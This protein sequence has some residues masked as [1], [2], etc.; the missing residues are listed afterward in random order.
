M[1]SHATG[2]TQ[3]SEDG[4]EDADE[5]LENELPEVLLGIIHR[6]DCGL[7]FGIVDRLGHTLVYNLFEYLL[8]KVAKKLLHNK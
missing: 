6:N 7:D 8:Q 4:R 1:D 2:C 5:G 3:C